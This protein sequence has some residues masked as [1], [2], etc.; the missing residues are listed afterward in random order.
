[1]RPLIVD[2][3]ID[4]FDYGRFLGAA[5]ESALGQTYPYA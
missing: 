5:I 1:V 2:V 4:N 3:V